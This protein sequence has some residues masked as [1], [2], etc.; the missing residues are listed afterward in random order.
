[1]SRKRIRLNI[2]GTGGAVRFT[3]TS[4]VSV[5]QTT[6][7]ESMTTEQKEYLTLQRIYS[8]NNVTVTVDAISNTLT[9][10]NLTIA[11]PPSGFPALDKYNFQ[12]FINGL[13]V[14]PSAITSITQVGSDV[15]IDFGAGLEYT[16]TDQMEITAVGKFEV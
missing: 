9:W 12:I 10:A 6:I 2:K 15:V 11:T 14:E 7:E 5:I 16:I 4:N 8:S 1:M 3:D 13:I